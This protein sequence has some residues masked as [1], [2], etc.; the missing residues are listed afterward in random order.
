MKLNLYVAIDRACDQ[1]DCYDIS[2]DQALHWFFSGLLQ[3]FANTRI[4][5]VELKYDHDD[6]FKLTLIVE[7]KEVAIDLSKEKICGQPCQSEEYAKAIALAAAGSV[8]Q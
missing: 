2:H 1:M 6:R 4:N 8:K 3:R 5:N 7:G